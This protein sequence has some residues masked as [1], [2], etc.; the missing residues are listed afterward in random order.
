MRT[1]QPLFKAN[2]IFGSREKEREDTE[3]GSRLASK[4][5]GKKIIDFNSALIVNCI[6]L[7]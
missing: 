6:T 5:K 2:D 4:Q 7:S 3:T 1:K